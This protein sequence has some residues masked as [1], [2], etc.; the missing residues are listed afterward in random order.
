MRREL[1]LCSEMPQLQPRLALVLLTRS[2]E[3]KSPS[4]TGRLAVQAIASAQTLILGTADQPIDWEGTRKSEHQALL[5]Y[6]SDDAIVLG[7][8]EA[9]FDEKIQLYVPDGNWRQ[10]SKMRRRNPFLASMTTVRLPS[11]IPTQYRIRQERKEGGLATVEAIA[12]AMRYLGEEESA[13]ALERI[14]QLKVQRIL[15]SRGQLESDS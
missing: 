5:L 15:F 7:S 11:T 3:W 4:N 9:K 14:F 8:A 6:P 12:Q 13:E 10:T 1:C 2:R